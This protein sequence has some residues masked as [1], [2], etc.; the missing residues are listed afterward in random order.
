VG[1]FKPDPTT[2]RHAAQVMD[3]HVSKSMLISAHDWDVAG[4]VGA[5]ASAAFVRRPGY[6]WSLPGPLPETIGT[7]LKEIADEL[8]G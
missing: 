1:R 6:V 5:G 2:Y 8:I 3:V 7:D 4:A